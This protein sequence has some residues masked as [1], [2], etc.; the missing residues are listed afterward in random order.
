MTSNPIYVR[1]FPIGTDL[2]SITIPGSETQSPASSRQ[3]IDLPDA[4]NRPAFR[5]DTMSKPILFY[6]KPGQLDTLTTYCTVKFIAE[7]T[8][9]ASKGA[10][11]ATHFRGPALTW[12]SRRLKLNPQFLANWDNFSTALSTSFGLDDIAA[13]QQAARQL[14]SCRQ[15]S[16]VQEYATKFRDLAE[17]AGIPD[18]TANA[19]FLKGLR[20]NVRNACIISDNNDS[21]TDTIAEAQRID[22]QLFYARSFQPG[23]G[24]GRKFAGGKSRHTGKFTPKIKTEY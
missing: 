24:G 12:L 8:P 1:S 21:L 18:Q 4:V 19:L 22:N 14:A 17:L 9:D 20:P 16:S 13:G 3:D 6:G 23:S 7:D 11:C 15:T 10:V 5:E 2:S